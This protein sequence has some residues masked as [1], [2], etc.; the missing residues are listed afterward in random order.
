MH[1]EQDKIQIG[2]VSHYPICLVELKKGETVHKFSVVL[3]TWYSHSRCPPF[4]LK[5]I[6]FQSATETFI[7]VSTMAASCS[8]TSEIISDSLFWLGFT[9][10][11]INPALVSMSGIYR[12]SKWPT[13]KFHLKFTNACFRNLHLKRGS[14]INNFSTGKQ[15]TVRFGDEKKNSTQYSGKKRC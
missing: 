6:T 9:V 12:S 5:A 13:L 3:V 14:Q 1:R 2:I 8:S 7:T 4:L 10:L 11:S 15:Q